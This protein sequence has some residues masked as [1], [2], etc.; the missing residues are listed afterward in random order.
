MYL[1]LVEVSVIR[2]FWEN[3]G[4]TLN[5]YL[6]TVSSSLM[7]FILKKKSDPLHHKDGFCF[8][9]DIV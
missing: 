1:T 6:I 7:R 9:S 3:R 4:G 2:L 5:F 8:D